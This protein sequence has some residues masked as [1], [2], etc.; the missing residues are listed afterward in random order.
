VI[1]LAERIGG[2]DALPRAAAFCAQMSGIIFS[3][4]VLRVAPIASMPVDEIVATLAP[5]LARTLRR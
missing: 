2:D 1:P 3:R 5:S 4:H